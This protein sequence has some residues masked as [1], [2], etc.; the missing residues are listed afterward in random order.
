MALTSMGVGKGGATGARAPWF[1]A[2]A[3]KSRP[4]V[5]FAIIHI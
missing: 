4:G 1:L 2:I 5:I 3:G